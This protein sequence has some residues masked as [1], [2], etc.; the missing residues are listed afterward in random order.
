MIRRPPRSTLFPYTT[1]F[2]SVV[3]GVQGPVPILR[4]S[5]VPEI[6]GSCRYGVPGVHYVGHPVA[7]SVH[8]G[9][10][11]GGGQKLHRAQ[12][13]GT[14][15]SQVLAVVRLD[16]PH[17]SQHVPVLHEPVLSRRLLV[18]P[19]VFPLGDRLHGL[20]DYLLAGD[21][22]LVTPTH[23]SP[24]G[25]SPRPEDAGPLRRPESLQPGLDSRVIRAYPGYGPVEF[26]LAAP[27][28]LGSFTL[29]GD[30]VLVVAPFLRDLARGVLQD[31]L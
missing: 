22:E 30:G 26:F 29:L 12:R 23:L 7:V 3:V 2:R 24:T 9:G 28:L 31:L 10:L 5:T 8:P 14:G 13:T 4:G 15:G 19:D 25:G 1:L 17:S 18:K 6:A 16:L 21:L 27:K 20:G 11:P